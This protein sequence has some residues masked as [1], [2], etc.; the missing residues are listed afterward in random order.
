MPG[1]TLQWSRASSAL[2]RLSSGGAR[3]LVNSRRDLARQFRFP[4]GVDLGSS[5]VSE[6]LMPA[7]LRYAGN[8]YSR[9]DRDMW[10]GRRSNI[11]IVIVSALYGLLTPEERIRDYDLTMNDHLPSG[12][13]V[14]RWWLNQGLPGLLA[15]F[16]ERTGVDVVHSFLSS[17]Y[18]WAA[19]A[20]DCVR[21]RD[22]KYP[23]LGSGADFHRGDD[24]RR[25]LE[26][27]AVR[28]G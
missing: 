27:H 26:A 4:G 10:P 3:T 18:A 13:R 6:P 14:S 5:G 23:R 20:V 25:L 15:E 11:D 9:I 8:L 7:R 24:V 19:E 12:I 21:I 22:H 28:R 16:V 2:G 1:G 17:T